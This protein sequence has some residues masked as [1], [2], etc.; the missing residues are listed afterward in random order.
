NSAVEGYN[1]QTVLTQSAGAQA[2]GAG[3]IGR[4]VQTVTVNRAYD[5]FVFGQLVQAESHGSALRSY[6]NE[7]SQ[8]DTLF[9]DRTVG[10]S[11][12]LERF[13][14]S[15]NAVASEPADPA[16]RE[17]MLGQANNLATQIRET[18][19]FLDKQRGNLNT[20]ITTVVD[21]VNSYI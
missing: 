18:N 1:R 21:Q 15:V 17:E 14:A 7:I 10:V 8:L 4:G 3:Y 13:F 11:P 20:Q 16:A 9:A 2:T 19:A 12:A 5:N 6:S